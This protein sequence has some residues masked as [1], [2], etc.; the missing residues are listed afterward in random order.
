M[1]KKNIFLI[2]ASIFT[3]I[4]TLFNTETASANEKT[5]ENVV[6][7]IEQDQIIVRRQYIKTYVRPFTTSSAPTTIWISLNGFSGNLTLYDEE[8]TNYGTVNGYYRGYI[9]NDNYPIPLKTPIETNSISWEITERRTFNV[10]FYD[11][12]TTISVNN[13]S[14]RGILKLVEAWEN[15]DGTWTGVYRGTVSTGNAAQNLI[16]EK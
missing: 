15:Q 14:Y 3:L 1:Y 16:K 9:Y 7:L 2:F 12:P 10:G 11:L 5:T 8:E 6:E 13:A 4:S